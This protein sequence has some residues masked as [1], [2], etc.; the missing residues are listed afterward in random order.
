MTVVI[1]STRSKPIES[2]LSKYLFRLSRLVWFSPL[3]GMHDRLTKELNEIGKPAHLG[4]SVLT[5]DSSAMLGY[6]VHLLGDPSSFSKEFGIPLLV[7]SYRN[8]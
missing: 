4:I 3:S 7:S 2:L 1:L 6:R 8:K 5:K